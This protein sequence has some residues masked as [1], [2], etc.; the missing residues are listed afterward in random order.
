MRCDVIGRIR[1]RFGCRPA[2]NVV[3]R[4]G[5]GAFGHACAIRHAFDITVGDHPPGPALGYEPGRTAGWATGPAAPV[6]GWRIE[7]VVAVVLLD[8]IFI[9]VKS[10]ALLGRALLLLGRAL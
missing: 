2:A 7:F 8:A 3:H 10:T 9:E 6:R 5:A 4:P 1:D